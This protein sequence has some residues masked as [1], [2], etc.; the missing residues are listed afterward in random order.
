MARNHAT[1][2][3][4]IWSDPD[5]VALK[6]T[7]QRLYLLLVS[8]PDLNSCGVIA[9]RPKVWARL[10]PDLSAVN[11]VRD[12][13][14]LAEARF[15]VVD[16]DTD[17]LV[18]RSFMRHDGVLKAPN[19][20]KAAARAF[21]TIHS[22]TVR[23]VVVAGLP[24]QVR[25]GFPAAF[26]GMHPK[27]IGAALKEALS[28]GFPEGFQ[29]PLS[30]GFGE[31]PV[32]ASSTLHPPPSS[33]SPSAKASPSPSPQP[34]PTEPIGDQAEHRSTNPEEDHPP[35][36][37]RTAALAIEHMARC[38]LRQAQAQGEPIKFPD[39]WLTKATATRRAAHHARIL[40]AATH[41]PGADPVTLAEELDPACGPDDGGLARAKAEAALSTQAAAQAE[42]TRAEYAAWLN[43]ADTAIAALDLDQ[44]ADLEARATETNP[45]LRRMELRRLALDPE[46][47]AP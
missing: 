45:T 30:E 21:G 15:I 38:D 46:T 40:E 32:R 22:T 5:F 7:A 31:P 16:E 17:E 26:I 42:A 43:E 3:S 41:R 44:L 2:Y 1:I 19:I 18:I 37:E 34:D 36:P 6:A 27:A 29:E 4:A 12:V 25:D 24:T 39:R 23:G 10:A 13:K 20:F 11:I 14:I 28:E 8:Q 9:Y 35:N 47:T 33:S